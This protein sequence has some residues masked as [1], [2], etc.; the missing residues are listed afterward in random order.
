MVRTRRDRNLL[1]VLWVVG[2]VVTTF[3]VTAR[4]GMEY[5]GVAIP[6]GSILGVV[7]YLMIYALTARPVAE[8]VAAAEAD[9]RRQPFQLD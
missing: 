1:A 4:L 3:I 6:L 5:L 9:R 2:A 8:D 7:V